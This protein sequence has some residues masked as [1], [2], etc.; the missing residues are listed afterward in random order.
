MKKLLLI[1]FCI[2][3][4]FASHSQETCATAVDVSATGTFIAPSYT[5]SYQVFCY[6]SKPGIKATWYKYIATADGELTISS[7]LPVNDGVSFTNDTRISVLKGACATSAATTICFDNADNV[8]TTNLLTNVTF[9][10]ASGTTYFI[11]WDNFGK[12]INPATPESLLGFEFSV[13]FIAGGCIRPNRN[14]NFLANDITTTSQTV[15]YQL[16]V[17]SPA[18]YDVDWSTNF[19]TAA[20]SGTIVNNVAGVNPTVFFLP[21]TS[22]PNESNFR[23][24]VRSNCGAGSTSVWQGPKYGY[25]A[26]TLPYSLTFEDATKL[27][28]DGFTGFGRIT[29]TATSFPGLADS[30]DG[31]GNTVITSNSATAVSNRR[32][33]TRAISLVAGEQVTFNFKTKLFPATSAPM[34]FDLTVGS[35]QVPSTQ[36]TIIQSFSEANAASFTLRTGTWTA[37][38]TG[39]YF[40]GFHNNSPQATT[41][42]IGNLVIDSISITSTILANELFNGKSFSIS[43]NPADKSIN[44]TNTENISISEITITDLNGRI[45]K[46]EKVNNISNVEINVSDLTTGMYL[47]KINS[48]KGIIT[49]KIIKN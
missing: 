3:S 12:A 6:G 19:S 45:V 14:S 8:S 23:Y 28:N 40:F 15:V 33:Y 31:F 38:T 35:N 47:M 9:P 11:Q 42:T 22:L 17:G 16:A 4:C 13:S 24:F 34:T 32:G 39:V 29:S 43:P 30:P 44:V 48:E 10:V 26:K 20:G 2:I 46:T 7:N 18:T 25:L 41:T 1:L 21:L 27:Y 5:G 36:T 37:P 49:K